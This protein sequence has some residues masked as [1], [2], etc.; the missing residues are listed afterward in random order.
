M[1]DRYWS[2]EAIRA[3]KNEICDFPG[4]PRSILVTIFGVHD[5]FISEN[6][7]IGQK[8]GIYFRLTKN[9][10]LGLK[11][12][13]KRRRVQKM[14]FLANSCAENEPFENSTWVL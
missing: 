14:R 4:V 2:N 1:T 3:L 12:I 5:Y 6:R 8:R 11:T 7:K 9:L 10:F 13:K